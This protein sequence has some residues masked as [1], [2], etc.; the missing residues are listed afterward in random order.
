MEKIFLQA[1][2]VISQI[3]RILKSIA[4]ITALIFVVWGV[5]YHLTDFVTVMQYIAIGAIVCIIN[6]MLR[7]FRQRKMTNVIYV[8][9]FWVLMAGVV[10]VLYHAGFE[11]ASVA[12]SAAFVSLPFFGATIYEGIVGLSLLLILIK[13]ICL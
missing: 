4:V 2:F 12:V 6:T 3:K 8:S 9:G 11:A 1:E 7:N 13:H 10:L 5:L